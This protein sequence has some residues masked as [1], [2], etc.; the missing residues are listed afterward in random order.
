MNIIFLFPLAYTPGQ[1][2]TYAQNYQDVW[3]EHI[4]KQN[5]WLKRPGF[6]IDMGAFKAL[7]CSNTALLDKKYNWTG[8]AIEPRAFDYSER[9]NTFLINRAV[10]NVDDDIISMAGTNGQIFNTLTYTNMRTNLMKVKTISP[11]GIYSCAKTNLCHSKFQVPKFVEFVS[12]DLEGHEIDA[13]SDW[14]WNEFSVG[15]FIIETGPNP[16]SKKC[17]QIRRTLK[18]HNYIRANVENRGVDDYFVLKQYWTGYTKK[19]WRVHPQNS[20]GC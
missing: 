8:I 20:G 6:F 7:E 19:A 14:P 3:F 18:G 16:C 9:N 13:F 17:R 11:K 2:G 10:T 4:A 5:G 15:V 1:D 12:M